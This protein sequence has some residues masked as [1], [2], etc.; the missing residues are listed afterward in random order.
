MKD[1]SIYSDKWIMSAQW[2]YARATS[3]KYKILAARFENEMLTRIPVSHL[4]EIEKLKYD[5]LN[6]KS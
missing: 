3:V 6:L 4:W 5:I 1:L 2:F